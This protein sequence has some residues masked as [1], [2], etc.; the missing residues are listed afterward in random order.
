MNDIDRLISIAARSKLAFIERF[1]GSPICG[2]AETW[3]VDHLSR[4]NGVS[5]AST[6]AD[7]EKFCEDTETETIIIPKDSFGLIMAKRILGRTGTSKNIV[8]EQSR[9]Q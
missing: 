8:I 1:A 7:F 6:P 3:V 5:I 4:Q 2:T 9:R